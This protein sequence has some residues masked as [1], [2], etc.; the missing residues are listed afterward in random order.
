MAEW[1]PDEHHEMTEFRR[2]ENQKAKKADDLAS[3]KIRLEKR[4]DA[5]IGKAEVDC[6]TFG[7]PLRTTE[8]N[9]AE[10]RDFGNKIR[11]SNR[12]GEMYT[13]TGFTGLLVNLREYRTKPSGP[14]PTVADLKKMQKQIKQ[15]KQT[16]QTNRAKRKKAALSSRPKKKRK[17]SEHAPIVDELG[18]N[19][20][21]PQQHAD[22][23]FG[24]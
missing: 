18:L 20:P 15:S 14:M 16:R 9:N 3:R 24:V 5:V 12:R 11:A 6:A 13:G 23:Y 2:L 21:C 22:D 8:F 1:A 4:K 7:K 19:L 17:K 10:M